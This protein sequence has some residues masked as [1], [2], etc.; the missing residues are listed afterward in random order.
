[1]K[2][3]RKILTPLESSAAWSGERFIITRKYDGETAVVQCEGRT[4][5]CERMK[6]RSGQFLTST[7]RALLAGGE[8]LAVF[9]IES[10]APAGERWTGLAAFFAGQGVKTLPDG[11]RLVLAESGSTGGYVHRVLDAGG[12]G[13][14]AKEIDAPFWAPFYAV[15][16]IESHD[17]KIIGLD[18]R[19]S[20]IELAT[21]D[22][23]PRGKCA[24]RAVFEG[25][26]LGDIV[27]VAAMGLTANGKLR[28]PRFIRIRRDK[29][30]KAA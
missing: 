17:L 21:L 15:K 7:D 30:E 5:I 28:E 20:S 24:A 4:L 14:C 29:M 10:T 6:P 16:R 1:M 26:N 19:A 18:D 2:L 22:G 11:R 27:E 8:F 12:E 3:P 23:E 25:L 9:D 13:V